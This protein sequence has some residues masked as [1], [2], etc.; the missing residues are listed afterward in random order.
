MYAIIYTGG[1][2]YRVSE[3]ESLFVEKLAV[4]EGET[5]IFDQV[6]VVNGKV[7]TPYV[8]GAKVT[9]KVEKHGKAPKIIV[10]KYKAKK[11]YRKKQGHRQ[12]FT[13][14]LITAIEG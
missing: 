4:N 9:A 8:E 14:V 13:K 6:L 7:G 1:K 11:N 5:V 3:N 10:Y 12:P 2:Q